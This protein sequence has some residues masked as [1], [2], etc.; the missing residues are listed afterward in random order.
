MSR[1]LL[2][3]YDGVIVDSEA[4]LG[5]ALIE[6]L[7]QDGVTI[8]YNDFGHLLG[9]TGPDNDRQ[10]ND[11]M[12]SLLGP[13]L[14][15]PALE[16]RIRDLT[17]PELP[18]LP[19][20]L[21]LMETAKSAG[22][23]LGL[24]TGNMGRLEFHLDRL[25]IAEHFDAVVRTHGTGIP[26]KPAPD[27]FLLLAEQLQVEPR[28]CVVIEDSVAGCEAALA[29]GMQV[30]ACPTIATRGCTFPDGIRFVTSL[31]EVEL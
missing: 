16:R 10:W 4:A 26:S 13:D 30:I 17:P 22:W 25:G 2:F 3:D 5:Q 9:M 28:D 19:G 27:V 7:A 8:T 1:G 23:K 12:C 14:D 11:F 20:V 31:L 15:M 29:A 21:S 18:L 6:I 24:G